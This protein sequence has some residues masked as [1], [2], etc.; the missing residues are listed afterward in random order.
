MR[1][2]TVTRKKRAKSKK[3][4]SGRPCFFRGAEQ[5]QQRAF[6]AIVGA[7]LAVS[8]DFFALGQPAADQL[9]QDRGLLRR[10]ESLAVDH[11]HA[12]PAVVQAFGQEGSEPMP[13]FIAVQAVQV[14]FILD[15]PAAASQVAQYI[16]GQAGTQMMRFVAA[17]QAVLQRDPAMQALMQRGLLVGQMLQRLGWWRAG[18]VLN[19]IGCGK[20]LDAGHRGA[21]SRFIR[22]ERAILG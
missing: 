22:T 5:D 3:G 4:D 2:A 12:T 16:L 20:R 6:A 15:H 9:A 17:F 19:D 18:A 13:R 14:D 8:Q 11:P 21:K 7:G 1:N 10:T